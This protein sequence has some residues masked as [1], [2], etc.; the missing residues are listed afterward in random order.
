MINEIFDQIEAAGGNCYYVGGCVRDHILG[1]AP[2]DYDIEVFGITVAQLQNILVKFVPK[3]KLIGATFGVFPVDNYEF[4][5]ARREN[6]IGLGHTDFEII[7]DP[8]LDV[9]TAASRRDYTINAIY[10]TRSG[11][12]IDPYN[13]ADDLKRGLLNIVGSKFSEDALRVLRGMQLS[14]RYNLAATPVTI[15]MARELLGGYHIISKDRIWAEWN[16]WASKSVKPSAGL[17]FLRQ[18][19]WIKAYPE[20]DYCQYT[21]Q[22]KRYHP[23]GNVWQHILHCVDATADSTLRFA[24]LVHDLGKPPVTH[25]TTDW[26]SPGHAQRPEPI[27]FMNGIGMPHELRDRIAEMVIHHMWHYE[28]ITKKRVRRLMAGLKDCSVQDIY[29][30]I[31]VDYA[32][33]PPLPAV[34]P[35]NAAKMLVVAAEVASEIKPILMGRHLID[36]GYKPGPVFSEIT[37]AAYEL[38]LDGIITNLDDALMWLDERN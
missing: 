33:R 23:E 32:G 28:P 6:K 35:K 8:Y 17:E 4:A 3:L 20:L 1:I 9:P 37:R 21:P 14:G 26:V 5:I 36:R 30:L 27:S 11:E 7:P 38:Q 2:D 16:K 18:S 29:D 24:G 22:S 12:I 34:V 13:G 19:H 25:F 10:R 31:V 15:A